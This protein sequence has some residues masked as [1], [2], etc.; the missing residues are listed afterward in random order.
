LSCSHSRTG[1]ELIAQRIG[2]YAKLVGREKL[3]VGS[4]CG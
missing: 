1:G 3:M 4:D 2:R